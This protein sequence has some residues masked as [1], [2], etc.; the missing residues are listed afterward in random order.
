MSHSI[1]MFS[2]RDVKDFVAALKSIVEN[3]TED[4]TV[5]YHLDMAAEH[6]DAAVHLQDAIDN[7]D[8]TALLDEIHREAGIHSVGGYEI[9]GGH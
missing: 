8:F 9:G 4:P 6:L 2:D 3:G 5:R 1:G 7:H